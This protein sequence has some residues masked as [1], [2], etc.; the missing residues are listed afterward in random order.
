M[1]S[2]FF[3]V[4]L[5]TATAT[6]LLAFVFLRNPIYPPRRG[7]SPFPVEKNRTTGLVYDVVGRRQGFKSIKGGRE[8]RIAVAGV[9]R[10]RFV[11]CVLEAGK[12]VGTTTEKT[13]A[14]AWKPQT[15][16]PI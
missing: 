12:C 4:I 9:L 6:A 3:L 11:C 7:A 1:A 13:P 14:N 8:G 15:G 16:L 5:S 2:S 10:A